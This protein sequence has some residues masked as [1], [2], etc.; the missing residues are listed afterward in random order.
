MIAVLSFAAAP[1]A[2]QD[3]TRV[4]R[5]TARAQQ[6]GT[7][8]VT[9]TRT[10]TDVF[11]V[12]VPVNVIDSAAIRERQVNGAADLFR[13]QPGLDVNGVGTNQVRPTIRGL[14][15][16]RILLLEDGLRLNNSRRQQDFGEL[17]AIV[18]LNDLQ[19]VEVVRGP[20]SVLYGTDAIGGVVNLITSGTPDAGAPRGVHGVFGYRHG[21]ADSQ[22]RPFAV[23]EQRAG[24]LGVRVGGSYRD[25]K[26]YDAPRGSFGDVTLGN[27]TR[28]NDTGVRDHNVSAIASFDIT[29]SQRLFAKGE[30]YHANDAGFGYVDPALFGAGQPLI[31]IR[32]PKQNVDKYTAGYRASALGSPLADRVEV[33]GFVTRNARD[34]DQHIFI[35]FGPGTP[36]GAGVDVTTHN[37]TDLATIGGRAEATKNTDT[38]TTTVVGFGPPRPRGD[39]TSKVPNAT[40]RT[41]GLFAQTTLT[42][43]EPLTVIVGG[44]V[45]DVQ[46]DPRAT[47]GSAAPL[48][49]SHERPVVGTASV[50][51]RALPQVNLIASVGRG[52]RAAN[53][54]E[55]FFEGATPEGSGY[56]RANPDLRSETSLNLDVGVRARSGP[57][58]AEAFVFRNDLRN[59]VA[60]AATGDSVNRVPAFRNVNIGKLRYTGGEAQVGATLWSRVTAIAGYSHLTSKDVQN[61]GNPIGDTYSEKLTG[62]VTYRDAGNRFW[63]A[64][65]VRHNGQQSN[66]AIGSTPV[67]PV[68]PSF[69]VHSLRGGVTLFERYGTRHSLTVAVDNLTNALYSEFS[70]A[71]FFRPETGRNFILSYGVGF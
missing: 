14:R 59:G 17:P 70:N 56:Q 29:K 13:D 65:A 9:A 12:A 68:I 55:R 27:R 53:L 6:L 51:Y 23:L 45:Q 50:V 15:G 63:T 41:A 37:F 25:T 22:E 47:V 16:Q 62:D 26:S 18:G 40:F 33:T 46:A 30:T 67:G 2:A 28:V 42:V 31:Q 36:P 54:V 35:P 4:R 39:G 38:S 58:F 69:T 61:P 60:I 48:S 8:T 10:P 21:S 32:Y 44:R 57:L 7:V 34:L 43:A 3:S 49:S 19:R 66:I 24:P 64:Y 11:S 52:F 71:S 5:D 1:L 20:L